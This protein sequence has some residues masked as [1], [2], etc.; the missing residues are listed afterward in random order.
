MERYD[1]DPS[2]GFE[3]RYRL[4]QSLFKR[5]EFVVDGYADRLKRPCRRVEPAGSGFK[6]DRP[7]DHGSE[8]ICR[9]Y[10][11]FRALFGYRSGNPIMISLLA[12][13]LYHLRK[14]AFSIPVHYVVGAYLEARIHPHVEARIKLHAESSRL[15]FYLVR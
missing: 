10:R 14:V 3:P 1:R 4:F 12:K 2:A 5:C 9:F 13:S 7:S 6:P 11:L 8:F 15:V